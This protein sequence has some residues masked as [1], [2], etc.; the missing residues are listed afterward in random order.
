[1]TWGGPMLVTRLHRPLPPVLAY[2]RSIGCMVTRMPAA[3][4]IWLDRAAYLAFL[5]SDLGRALG[6][7]PNIA[8]LRMRDYAVD[9]APTQVTRGMSV[10]VS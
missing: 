10:P 9:E 4:Y 1:M 8:N 2:W 6:N 5:D 3:V 7:H